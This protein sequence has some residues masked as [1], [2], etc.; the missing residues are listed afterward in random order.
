MIV[1]PPLTLRIDR[2][3]DEI[4]LQTV[5]SKPAFSA[6]ALLTWTMEPPAIDAGVPAPIV[7][8]VSQLAV[9][10]GLVAFRMF[11]PEELPSGIVRLPPPRQW[12]PVRLYRRITRSWLVEIV[13]AQEAAGAAELFSQ[14]WQLQ[15]QTALVL[16]DGSMSETTLDR[17]RRARDWRDAGFPGGARLL[18]SPAVDG[19][20]ILLAAA[21]ATEVEYAL[22]LLLQACEEAGF[23]VCCGSPTSAELSDMDVTV[24]RYVDASEPNAEGYCDYHYEYDVYQFSLGGSTYVA[25]SYIDDPDRA[26]FLSCL[27]G[28]GS[29]LLSSVNLVHPLLVA[30]ADYL[31]DAGKTILERLSQSEGY[32]PLE[33]PSLPKRPYSTIPQRL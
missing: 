1:R 31:R 33:V 28:D 25:R 26:A 8:I 14:G 5:Q 23:S 19:D 13:I 7:E 27:D 9:S 2:S 29:R 17:L 4:L 32:V 15:G 3:W 22:G 12:L 24:S 30:A 20:G 16:S 6:A 11:F 18:I 21:S 10:M